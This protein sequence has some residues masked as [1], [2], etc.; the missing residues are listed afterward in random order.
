MNETEFVSALQQ[1]WSCGGDPSTICVGPTLYN[2][3]S[4]YTGLATR[5]RD[6]GSKQQ[7]Q[8]V[9]AASVYVNMAAH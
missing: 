4:S 8:I 3:I 7:A 2:R 9:G 6:V 5:F 1:A